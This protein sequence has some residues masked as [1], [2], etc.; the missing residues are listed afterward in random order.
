MTYLISF[1]WCSWYIST[2]QNNQ[3]VIAETKIG[4]KTSTDG[5][6]TSSVDPPRSSLSKE[7][8][9][10]PVICAFFTEKREK[11]SGLSLK[12]ATAAKVNHW[13]NIQKD[14]LHFNWAVPGWL[15]SSLLWYKHSEN[16]MSFGWQAETQLKPILKMRHSSFSINAS[17]GKQNQATVVTW[18]RAALIFYVAS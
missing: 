5:K 1:R 18:E 6:P 11:T 3:R 7:T 17:Q 2:S 9:P 13:Q 10:L 14:R 15:F 4:C 8:C 12:Q 16:C